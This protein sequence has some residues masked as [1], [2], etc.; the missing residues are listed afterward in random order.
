MTP[1]QPFSLEALDTPALVVDLDCMEQNLKRM[2]TFADQHSVALRPHTKAH[3]IP[4]LAALQLEM[5]A[6]GICVAK[7][8][9]AEVMLASGIKDILITTP[10]ANP[11]KLER[12]AN[13]YVR[14]PGARIIQVIDHPD[15]A[16]AIDSIATKN[17][18]TIEVLLEVECG[19]KRCGIEVGFG[20]KTLIEL[21]NALPSIKYSGIQAYTGHLQHVRDYQ[22]R[23][24]LARISVEPVFDFINTYLTTEALRPEVVSGGGSGTYDAYE[25]IPFT[26]LQA[27]SY[28][29]MDWDY[30]TIGSRNGSATYQD[31][32]CALKVW[33]T[34]ISQPEPGRAVV[35]AGMKCLS[36]DS[37]MPHVEGHKDIQYQTGGDE[38]GILHYPESN[39]GVKIGQRMMIIPSHCD[40]TLNQYSKLYGIRNGMVEQCW[41]IE[42]R[43]RSD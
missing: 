17:G 39:Q 12:L 6:K 19:Q 16:N 18:V 13:L 22:E 2:Q 40:T 14:Y 1:S 25:G 7:L 30:H 42:G 4:E 9:E 34:V 21:I 41:L 11:I 24:K 36:I 26:E 29:F 20:L 27:G 37:G 33:T 32:D 15:H 35:D 10:I 28:L 31:F 38:H 8:G 43:G 23:I 5:G 3:K